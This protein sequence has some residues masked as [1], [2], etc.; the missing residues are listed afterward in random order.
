[1]VSYLFQQQVVLAFLEKMRK[2]RFASLTK[3]AFYLKFI[4]E[5]AKI[6]IWLENAKIYIQL[7]AAR[8][9]LPTQLRCNSGNQGQ[10]SW[11]SSNTTRI[12]QSF[13]FMSIYN[14]SDITF[15]PFCHFSLLSLAWSLP[16]RGFYIFTDIN[17]YQVESVEE[18]EIF[19]V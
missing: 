12:Y 13:M 17:S 15:L 19:L 7:V 5:M 1:M 2:W 16:E 11:I 3:K 4:E 6:Y 8:S 18:K 10:K 9:P 14:T